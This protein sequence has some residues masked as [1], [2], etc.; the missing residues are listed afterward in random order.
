MND[1]VTIAL[2]ANFVLDLLAS[3]GLGVLVLC[4]LYVLLLPKSGDNRLASA[5]LLL[6]SAVAFTAVLSNCASTPPPA[7]PSTTT[8]MDYCQS[9]IVLACYRHEM[10]AGNALPESCETAGGDGICDN[11]GGITGE[12][13]D[14]CAEALLTESCTIK[15]PAACRGIGTDTTKAPAGEV[16][17]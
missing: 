1:P 3:M 4:A 7:P 12:E 14:T 9:L 15:Y 2:S 10:C 13:A 6:I 8:S 5:I 16:D 11:I 17:L